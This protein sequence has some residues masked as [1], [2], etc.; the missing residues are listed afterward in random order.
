M[1]QSRNKFEL[2][3]QRERPLSARSV[4]AS[5][6]LGRRSARA[7]GGDLVRWCGLFGIA[8]GTARV[9]LHRMTGAGEL[10]RD[11]HGEY[12]LVGPLARRQREQQS[13]LSAQL[14]VWDGTWRMAIAVGDARPARVRADVRTALK[15]ARLAEWREGVWIRP[16]NVP[17]LVE[18][19]RCSWLDARPDAD[20][21]ALAD[22][23]FAPRAWREVADDLLTQ[24]HGATDIMR[25]DRELAIADA[26][27]AGA[28]ALRHIRVDPLLPAALLPD[29]WPGTALR[30]AYRHY[31]QEFNARARD[32]FRAGTS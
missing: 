12:L 30:D 15:R 17:D 13:S 23:L 18:D 28:A 9:A 3:G 29:P 11:D 6:L 21:V 32:W 22:D 10:E 19:P 7:G 24:L 5:L 25:T 27:L 20:P 8:P 14:S 2:V 1:E 26:F 31:Q 4:M 16:A